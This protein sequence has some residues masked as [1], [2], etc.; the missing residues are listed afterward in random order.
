MST[1]DSLHLA[2]SSDDKGSCLHREASASKV[3]HNGLGRIA[4]H[5][6]VMNENLVESDAVDL[7][8]SRSGDESMSLYRIAQIRD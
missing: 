1:R 2:Y 3:F 8:I 4:G 5:Y 7:K 6:H